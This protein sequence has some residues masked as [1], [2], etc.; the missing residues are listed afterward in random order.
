MFLQV[1]IYYTPFKDLNTNTSGTVDSL[2]L[3]KKYRGERAYR[4]I[5][6]SDR[7]RERGHES[8]TDARESPQNISHTH[9]HSSQLKND[10]IF[11]EPSSLLNLFNYSIENNHQM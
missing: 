2:G 6:Y 3:G 4:F 7:E 1:V 9:T 10:T 11:T 5:M 8:Q